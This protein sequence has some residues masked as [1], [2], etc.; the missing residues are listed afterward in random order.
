[1]RG[2]AKPQP[3]VTPPTQPP[4]TPD[5]PITWHDFSGQI[6]IDGDEATLRFNWRDIEAKREVNA[7]SFIR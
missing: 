1:M 2:S 4:T 3:P 5:Q 6:A 7:M